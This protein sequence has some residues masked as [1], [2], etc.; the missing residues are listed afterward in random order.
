MKDTKETKHPNETRDLGLSFAK[1][2]VL[3]PIGKNLNKGCR[4]DNYGISMLFV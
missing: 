4:L 2:D 3:G 1:K